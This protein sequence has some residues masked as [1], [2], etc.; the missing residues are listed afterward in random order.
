M[1]EITK[2]P[3]FWAVELS[4]HDLADIEVQKVPKINQQYRRELVQDMLDE[5]EDE[6]RIWRA[7]IRSLSQAADML[8]HGWQRGADR[9]LLMG[10]RLADRMPDPMTRKR[11][12]KYSNEG[13]EF[14]WDRYYAR[15]DP[16]SSWETRYR[17]I[18]QGTGALLTIAMQW[19]G[20]G[21]L[22]AKQMYWTGAAAVALTDALEQA[23]YSLQVLLIDHVTWKRPKKR[24]Q[25]TVVRAKEPGE[26]VE[27][28]SLAALCAHSGIYRSLGL[29]VTHLVPWDCTSGFGV[30]AGLTDALPLLIDQRIIDPVQIVVPK[31]KS[32][33]HALE[34]LA[35]TIDDVNAANIEALEV[36]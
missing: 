22:S 9:A 10:E 33:E 13:E 32:E 8:R 25:L 28:S 18:R 2:D 31:L 20:N 17:D 11:Q 4:A 36:R 1:T 34:F 7:G 21:G 26:P 3:S 12:R 24:K 19:G 16:E 35:A 23:G 5:N 29:A 15:W 14:C 27:I 30:A 6:N